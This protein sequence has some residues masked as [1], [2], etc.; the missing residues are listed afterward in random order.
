[1]LLRPSTLTKANIVKGNV[2]IASDGKLL[3]FPKNSLRM[4]LLP[5]IP[6][7]RQS[8]S[9][10]ARGA[11]RMRDQFFIRRYPHMGRGAKL[12]FTIELFCRRKQADV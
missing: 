5:R 9:G 10:V 12:R 4:L 2:R 6:V 7:L 3:R 8:N 11:N 1:M